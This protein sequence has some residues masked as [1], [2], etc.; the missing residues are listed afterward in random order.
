MS[1]P[2]SKRQPHRR[3][4]RDARQRDPSEIAAT[5]FG[6]VGRRYLDTLTAT[7]RSIR[8]ESLRLGFLAELFGTAQ[9]QSAMVEVMRTG[10]VGVEY[11]EYILRHKRK[12]E[13]ACTPLEWA[14]PP[15]TP[16]PLA[17][18]ISRSLIHRP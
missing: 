2:S 11:V 18:P 16:S 1:A 8:R 15:S 13:P 9:T 3:E 6:S 17:S 12:L 14:I 5:R 4:L 7:S 10:H